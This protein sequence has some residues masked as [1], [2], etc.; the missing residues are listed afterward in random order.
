MATTVGADLEEATRVV[1]SD[2]D[3]GRLT[4][5]LS[6]AW[7]IWGPNGG[8]LAAIALRA[9]ATQAQIAQPASFYCHFLTSPSFADVDVEVTMLRAGRR[10]EALAVHMSQD[11]KPVLHAMVRTAADGVGHDYQHAVAPDIPKPDEL[12][13]LD[14]L[15][16]PENARH[17][18]FWDNVERCPV[19]QELPEPGGDPVVRDWARFRPT[20]TFDDPFLDAA[21]SLI[22]L[23]TYGYPASWQRYRDEQIGAPNLDTAAWFHRASPDSEWLLIDETC[24]VG[25]RGLLGISGRVWDTDGR[26]VASGGAQ[27]VCLDGRP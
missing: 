19:P 9:A 22:L 15:I 11:G 23:D 21:R 13:T 2:G 10:S 17:F 7:E 8:Y 1:P 18:P 26:L 12:R 20:A 4:A 24:L 3:G 27:L 5:T 14:E 16:G 25:D 6:S